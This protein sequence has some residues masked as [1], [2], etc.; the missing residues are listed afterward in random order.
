MVRLGIGLYGVDANVNLEQVSTLKTSISQIKI[1]P[2]G[3]TVGYG[4]KGELLKDT[5]VATVKIGYADGY[6]RSLS[7]GAGYMSLHGKMVPVI[8][9]VCMDMTMLD[10]TDVDAKIGDEV[11]VFGLQLPIQQLSKWANTIPYEIMTGINQ[12]V[13]RIYFE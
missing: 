4:R 6:P 7:N 5:K 10:I 2:A 1:I 13:K 9:N 8:G 3:E 11:I 12:R